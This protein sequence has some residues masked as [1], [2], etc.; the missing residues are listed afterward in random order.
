M[1]QARVAHV[2]DAN[3]VIILLLFYFRIAGNAGKA[4]NAETQW[5]LKSTSSKQQ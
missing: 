2:T 5:R 1:F 4:N 3:L